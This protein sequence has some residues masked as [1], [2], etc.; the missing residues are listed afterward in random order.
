MQSQEV[1]NLIIARLFPGENVFE[2][3]KAICSKHNLIAGV[4]VSGVGQFGFIELGFFKEKGNYMS[5]KLESPL[6]VLNIA[7]IISKNEKKEYDFHLH[8]ALSD[9][10]KKAF[11]GHFI[12]GMVS[13]TL[14]VAILKTGIAI[15]RRTEEETGL[16]GLFL[17]QNSNF[18][19]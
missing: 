1:N 16:S 7:G 2:Q 15:K 8:I 13:I 3:L 9:E 19:F 6:E 18:K 11:G 10:N 14:E 17:E 5:Q 4:I 12:N